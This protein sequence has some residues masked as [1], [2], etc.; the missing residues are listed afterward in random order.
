MCGIVAVMRKGAT[1]EPP[2]ADTAKRELSEAAAWFRTL[3]PSRVTADEVPHFDGVAERLAGLDRR[4]RGPAGVTALLRDEELARL[5]D[6][7]CGE[8]QRS[9]AE[10]ER[11]LDEGRVSFGEDTERGNA[12]LVRL[13]DVLWSLS[14]DRLHTAQMVADLAGDTTESSAIAGYTCIQ[15]ALSALDRLEVRGRDSAGLQVI[16][17]GSELRPGSDLWQELVGDR[18]RDPLF[19]SGAV[20]WCPESMTL[21]YKAAAEIGELGD[22]SA[23]LRE[24][25]RRDQ[26]L[27][28]VLVEEGATVWVLAHTRWASV[29]IVSEAN[30]HPVV[31][32]VP[33]GA[34]APWITAALNGDV[35]NHAELAAAERLSTP[36]QLTTDARVIP[37]LMAKYVARGVGSLESFLDTVRSLE[38]SVAI[39]SVRG[40]EPSRLYLALRGSGQ[41]LYIGMADGVFVVASEPYGVVEIADAYLRMEG[42]RP[43]DPERPTSRGQVVVLDLARAGEISGMSRHAYDGT[44]LPV[45][46]EELRRPEVTTRDIDRGPYP[47]YLLKEISESPTS[48]KK[49]LRGR[50]VD[51]GDRLGV[52]LDGAALP[53]PLAEKIREGGVRRVVAIGQGTAF[54]AAQAFEH[55]MRVM[56]GEV[57]PARATTAAELS[58]FGLEPDM[59]DTLVVA[60]SQSGTTTDTNRTVDL[61][62]SR[63]APVLAIVN[64]RNSDLTD[65]ADAVLFTSD[66][67]DVEMSVASTKAFYSQVAA[68]FLLAGAVSSLLGLFDS[69]QAQVLRALA[70]LPDE[71]QRVVARREVIADVAQRL[72]P[73]RRHW[74]VVGNGAD[75]IAARELRIKLS[76][77]CYKSIACDSTEDKKHIDLSVGAS[78]DRVCGVTAGVQRR[79][80]GQGG[81]DLR[82][83]QGGRGGDRP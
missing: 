8:I 11:L 38:G 39:A 25:I 12:A 28:H 79:R 70:E 82:G 7:A 42:E 76:E 20:R 57:L 10:L 45:A 22:N 66:G 44:P 52:R 27:R 1:R 56:V 17:A 50:L 6:E 9:L 77:L 49:T 61:V 31:A 24:Q 34:D 54:V 59:S 68:G 36:P 43:I 62:R 33:D 74:A 81:R 46:P 37:A 41:A 58:G 78:G 40:D 16:V 30:A 23:R 4:L 65:R 15:E 63:G 67:R 47:H 83:T 32:E 48:F 5:V 55:A 3:D 69:R 18:D 53:E 60:V 80:R 21:V 75:L 71:M 13:K 29:G 35:D 14:H 64:R 73:P 26:L 2:A 19:C 51:L 72:A